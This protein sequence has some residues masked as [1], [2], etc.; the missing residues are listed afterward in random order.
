MSTGS[1]VTQA[2]QK[3]EEAFVVEVVREHASSLLALARRYSH[4][5]DD[6][7]DAYQRGLE[8][9]LRRAGDVERATAVSW[10]R[11]VIKNEALA[12]RAGRSDSV[13]VR[14]VD[15]DRHEATRLPTPDEQISR[16]D[17][18]TRAAE[19]LQRL[20]PQ[21]VTALLLKA[22]GHSYQEISEQTGWTYTKVNRCI[23]EG[24]RRFIERYT[25]IESGA[26]CELWQPSLSAMADGEASARQ[27]LDL[28][29]HLRSCPACRAALREHH[30]AARRVAALMPA[31]LL[32]AGTASAHRPGGLLMRTYEALTG[33]VHERLSA[34]AL[35]LQTAA[36][37]ATSGK[38]AA[39]AAS[40]AA[41]AGGG[42]VILHEELETPK[43][44][45]IPAARE[46]A[47][48]RRPARHR[49]RLAAEVTPTVAP[50]PEA[51]KTSG[52][53]EHQ[54]SG[55]TPQKA[56]PPAGTTPAAPTTQT[57]PPA[58]QEFAP[59]QQAAAPSSSASSPARSAPR[60][61]RAAAPTRASGG[62]SSGEFSP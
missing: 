59:E 11:T 14:D 61:A 56:A 50:A 35:K 25:R 20:K 45:S 41:L 19:A 13:S 62:G 21:E 3:A 49:A 46:A 23:T 53:V 28:R 7:A 9:F 32:L 51:P 18:A 5:A 33:G 44:G 2:E 31:G 16:F 24:R 27:V 36:E 29:P 22:E 43:R 10:L 12:I 48:I 55:T 52:P 37:A 30:G 40:T 39:V 58:Q 54:G 60:P 42:G 4:C 38:L 34:S 17:R 47:H 57:V 6:A 15:L 1:V 26:E 8:I